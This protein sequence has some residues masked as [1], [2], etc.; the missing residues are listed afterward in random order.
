[1]RQTL[2]PANSEKEEEW[3]IRGAAVVAAPRRRPPL[4]APNIGGGTP[5]SPRCS[6]HPLFRSPPPRRGETA[7]YISGAATLGGAKTLGGI[8]SEAGAWFD[9]K[10]PTVTGN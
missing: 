5:C 8:D 6:P 3:T 1:M 2:L 10:L 9:L 4:R 7:L